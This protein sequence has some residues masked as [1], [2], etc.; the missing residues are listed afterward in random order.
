MQPIYDDDMVILG[1]YNDKMN[2]AKKRRT[3]RALFR[4]LFEIEKEQKEYEK[5]IKTFPLDYGKMP[6]SSKKIEQMKMESQ[7]I[8]RKLGIAREE[9]LEELIERMRKEY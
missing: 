3:E 1:F 2:K 8:Q 6:T 9:Q 5:H 7:N 4:L